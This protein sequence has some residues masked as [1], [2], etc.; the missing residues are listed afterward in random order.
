MAEC[1]MAFFVAQ[2]ILQMAAE[3]SLYLI[4]LVPDAA[5]RARIRSLKEEMKQRFG[6]SHALKSPAHITL[7]MPFRRPVSLEPELFQS[8]ESLA[9]R[10]GAFKL[11]LKG[12][13]C[14]PPRVL[15]VKVQ[16]QE[17]VK[18]LHSQLQK[19]LKEAFGFSERELG[20]RF[21]PHLTIATRDLTEEA[22]REAWPEFSVRSFEAIFQVKSLF[23]LKHNGKTW[24][25]QREFPF[26]GAETG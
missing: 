16:N 15:F 13:D 18:K 10:Q 8:L 9:N 7:Q 4:A 11:P 5:L 20:F 17:A 3:K 12:F 2:T 14:F 26:S 25:C 1:A 21:H 22:F 24:D 6:A 19:V 23:L